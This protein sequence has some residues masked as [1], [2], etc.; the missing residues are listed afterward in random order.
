VRDI[1]MLIHG[2]VLFKWLGLPAATWINPDSRFSER[3]LTHV[4]DAAVQ[5]FSW[6]G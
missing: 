4:A 6:P 1:F 2:T 3:L 5:S